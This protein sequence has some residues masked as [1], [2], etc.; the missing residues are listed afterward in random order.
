MGRHQRRAVTKRS[1]TGNPQVDR[2]AVAYRSTCGLHHRLGEG[3]KAQLQV[4]ENIINVLNAYCQAHK[5]R[6]HADLLQL[7]S[8]KL[9]VGGGG[10][11]NHE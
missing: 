1:V 4:G 6:V 7:L 8:G 3:V 11:V 9:G 10:G 2:K 5:V